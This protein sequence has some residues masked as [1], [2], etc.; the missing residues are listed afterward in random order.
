MKISSQFLLTG[1]VILGINFMSF[2]QNVKQQKSN[3]GPLSE[4][5]KMSAPEHKSIVIQN[6]SSNTNS[7]NDYFLRLS[8]EIHS[9]NSQLKFKQIPVNSIPSTK[10]NLLEKQ[11]FFCKEVESYGFENLPLEVQGTY[12]KCLKIID[13][14]K[15]KEF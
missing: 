1:I 7:R 14:E 5:K 11:K 4:T 13:P 6:Q 9:T 3:S 8:S 12:L 2:G 10:T 15:R